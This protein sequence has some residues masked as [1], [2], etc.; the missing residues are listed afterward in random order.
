MAEIEITPTTYGA[1]QLTGLSIRTRNQDEM[2]PS[3]G[4]IPGLWE[5]FYRDLFPH[6]AAGS[7]AYGVYTNYASDHNGYYDLSAAVA[8]TH[9]TNPTKA[10]V[11]TQ[12]QAGPY[13]KFAP[14]SPGK[15]PVKQIMELW[16]QVWTHFADK[17]CAHERAYTTDF[18]LYHPEMTVE[19]FISVK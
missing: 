1:T 15:D 17:N 19:L 16:Q 14:K 10:C 11:P 13:L 4:K 2:P 18:E 7:P 12:I 5:S 9:L 3:T 8:S 6:V